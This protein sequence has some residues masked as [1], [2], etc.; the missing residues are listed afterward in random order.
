MVGG[1]VDY[2]LRGVYLPLVTTHE[3]HCR[4]KWTLLPSHTI[5]WFNSN[6]PLALLLLVYLLSIPLYQPPAASDWQQQRK[7]YRVQSG[8]EIESNRD[9]IKWEHTIVIQDG[10][11]PRKG[12]SAVIVK[13]TSNC[14]ATTGQLNGEWEVA[15]NPVIKIARPY[16]YILANWLLVLSGNIMQK[17]CFCVCPKGFRMAP[18]A[19]YNPSSLTRT[20]HSTDRVLGSRMG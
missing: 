20:T 12:F 18:P 4:E 5:N 6:A 1:G 16:T 15:I 19:D 7:L 8:G 3:G 9:T 17:R 10:M 13:C 14:L 2:S 11:W